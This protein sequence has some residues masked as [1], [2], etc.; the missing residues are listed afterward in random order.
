[1]LRELV[2][3]SLDAGSDRVEVS[4]DAIPSEEGNGDSVVYSLSISDTGSGMDEA[5][6][7]GGLTRLFAT[8][9]ADDRTMA[10]GFGIGF[11][12]V[13]AWQ[14]EAV[15]VQT[16]K[17]GESWEVLFYGGS[18]SFEKRRLEVPVEGTTVTLLR[19]GSAR[20]GRQIA[21]AVRDSLWRWCRY[22][23]L[24]ITFE[25]LSSDEPLELIQDSPAS[26]GGE[27]SVHEEAGDHSIRVGF[28]VPSRAVLLRRGLILAEGSVS[29]LLPGFAE[30][31]GA[32][33]E[34]LQVWVDSPSLR[35]TL[36]R[37]KVVLDGGHD[38]TIAKVNA[39]VATLRERLISALIASAAAGVGKGES[40]GDE[41]AATKAV[42]EGEEKEKEKEKEKETDSWGSAWGRAE[43]SRYAFLHGHLAAE[44][45]QVGSRL[46]ELAVLRE[47]TA[48]RAC[49][50]AELARALDGRPLIYT[51]SGPQ[52][53]DGALLG[54][55]RAIRYPVIAGHEGDRP[56][57]A[58][59]SEEIGVGL[60]RLGDALGE[61]LPVT[62][63]GA[64]ERVR[65]VTEAVLREQGGRF[66][67]LRLRVGDFVGDRPLPALVA[68]ELARGDRIVVLHSIDALAN[69]LPATL[70]VDVD[71]PLLRVVTKAEKATPVAAVLGLAAAIAGLVGAGEYD[72]EEL[73]E[74]VRVHCDRQS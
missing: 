8:T 1:F 52:G 9:K 21:E 40:T 62:C 71:E 59:F 15:L 48:E 64:C 37:D 32:G 68:T 16:G 34:H 14:P 69:R 70:W 41:D 33:A 47:R 2:Q 29:G 72:P 44:R 67:D 51:T 55:A 5:I 36:A 20:E 11:V 7:D 38:Q 13:F 42:W 45:Q 43:H 10:G 58:G 18:R 54:M 61:V 6:I 25:D 57:L 66:K 60:V 46:A 24:E 63:E 56:W 30:T 28:A 49:T 27:L 26:L 3:N 39:A 53:P 17:T 31:L 12:S 4:L 22:C 73:A 65:A 19:R 23:R 50:P 35:T 74:A